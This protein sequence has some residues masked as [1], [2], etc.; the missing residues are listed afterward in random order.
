MRID[1]TL[2]FEVPYLVHSSGIGISDETACCRARIDFA[3]LLPSL[4]G[5]ICLNHATER[6]DRFE[7]VRCQR[8]AMPEFIGDFINRVAW[9]SIHKVCCSRDSFCPE[10]FGHIGLIEHCTS[11]VVEG[12]IEPFSFAVRLR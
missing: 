5:D 12:T 9:Q 10:G 2:P 1:K 6:L 8:P 3:E 11:V 7:I 4:F